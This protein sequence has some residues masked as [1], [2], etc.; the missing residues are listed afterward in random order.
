M[1]G[2]G[3]A[4][5]PPRPD[6]NASGGRLELK[7][8]RDVDSESAAGRLLDPDRCL[9]LVEPSLEQQQ[10]TL[11]VVLEARQLERRIES[12]FPVRELGAARGDVLRQQRPEDAA[13]DTLD[14]VV[15]VEERA[16]VGCEVAHDDR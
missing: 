8:R 7:L 3:G 10:T 13:G 4:Y 1:S 5:A 2:L 11:Q 6:M 12:K 16:G 9:T 14:E 15:A